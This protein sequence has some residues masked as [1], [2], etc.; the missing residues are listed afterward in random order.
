M[1][2][3]PKA[4]RENRE[5]AG[6]LVPASHPGLPA[7]RDPYSALGGYTSGPD[8]TPVPFRVT[9]LA[10]WRIV[11]K[12]KWVILSILGAFV[13]FGALKTLMETPL[14][15]ATRSAADRPGRGEGGR[16]RQRYRRQIAIVWIS[17][18][19][20]MSCSRAEQWA[21]ASPLNCD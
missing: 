20:N 19:P 12:R 9:L 7:A 14:Y 5:E 1:Q 2:D 6:K 16:G 11:N 17:S 4:P 13:A 3:R 21:S 8:D 18:E 10:Y 15:T